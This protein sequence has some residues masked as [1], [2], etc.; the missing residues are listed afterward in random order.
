MITSTMTVNG[1]DFGKSS[2]KLFNAEYIRKWPQIAVAY[3]LPLNTCSTPYT[4]ATDQY[5]ES[6][7]F[8]LSL[9]ILTGQAKTFEVGRLYYL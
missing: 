3:A 5:F 6:L 2:S 4:I 1:V 8:V 9:S 7:R